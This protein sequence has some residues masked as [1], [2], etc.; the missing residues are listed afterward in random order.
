MNR[1]N[2][3]SYAQFFFWCFIATC[4]FGFD[5]HR[6]CHKLASTMEI[7][8][9]LTPIPSLSPD[10]VNRLYVTSMFNEYINNSNI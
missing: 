6:L 7:M 10:P 8:I 2:K 9:K 5:Q 1:T 3:H 4:E